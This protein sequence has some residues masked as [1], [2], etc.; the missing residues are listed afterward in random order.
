MKGWTRWVLPAMALALVPAGATAQGPPG[1]GPGGP[2]GFSM[3]PEMMAK[4]RKWR[5]WRENHKNYDAL[6]QTLMGFR[7]IEND[8]RIQL[9]KDQAR[10]ILKVIKAWQ[11]KP[12]LTDDQ[13]RQV[14]VALTK[15]LND[16]QLKKIATVRL[17]GRGGR[18]F[19]GGGGGFGGG[20]PGGGP[21]GGGPPGGGRPGGPGGGPGGRPN[22]TFPDP[23]EYNPLNPDTNPFAKANPQMGQR[24]KSG[25][26]EF[27]AKL[28]AK[29]K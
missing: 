17:P 26:N 8:P 19:G 9:S 2:G 24:I 14:N 20:R 23:V 7:E 1:G 16:Q 12:R 22:F 5:Q 4:I 27:M 3:P 21:P 15:G 28:Q 10:E 6:Q 29:A 13:A 18:G 11:G 25:M